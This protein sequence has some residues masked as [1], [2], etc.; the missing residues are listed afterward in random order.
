MTDR[1]INPLRKLAFIERIG[2][3]PPGHP[4]RVLEFDW[5]MARRQVTHASRPSHANSA[6]FRD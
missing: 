3:L 4:P 1:S 5:R 2:T 6:K